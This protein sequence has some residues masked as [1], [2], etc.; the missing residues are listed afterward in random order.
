[1]RIAVLILTAVVAVISVLIVRIAVIEHMEISGRLIG[2]GNRRVGRF[3]RVRLLGDGRQRCLA[4]VMILMLVLGR[5]TTTRR[6]TGSRVQIVLALAAAVVGA[7]TPVRWRRRWRRDAMAMFDRHQF[8]GGADDA[9]Q[10]GEEEQ[11]V[12]HT[13]RQ[14]GEQHPEEVAHDELEG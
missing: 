11:T 6:R 4:V 14:H 1:M 7:S 2:G 13:D 5:R 9:E 10:H 8:G 12:D 3:P